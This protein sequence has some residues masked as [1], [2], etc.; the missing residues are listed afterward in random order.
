MNKCGPAPANAPPLKWAWSASFPRNCGIKPSSTPASPTSPAWLPPADR[1][2][3]RRKIRA[4]FCSDLMDDH[5]RLA[6][7][8]LVSK[9]QRLITDF[10]PDL[11][12]LQELRQS[13][14]QGH[15]LDG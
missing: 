12:G 2:S 11:E 6:I 9:N 15:I 1:P 13:L 7:L 10:E 8:S 5:V 14:P 3:P 4:D